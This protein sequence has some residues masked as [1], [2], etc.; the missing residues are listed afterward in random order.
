MPRLGSTLEMNHVEFF[1][2]SR[3]E[4]CGTSLHRRLNLDE[5]YVERIKKDFRIPDYCDAW[6]LY[7]SDPACWARYYN[8]PSNVI[9][10]QSE[11]VRDSA[12]AAG[13]P[14]RRNVFEYGYPEPD[15]RPRPAGGSPS[16]RASRSP[17]SFAS[18]FGNWTAS[19]SSSAPAA[20]DVPAARA[21]DVRLADIRRLTRMPP[22]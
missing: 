12:A 22:T 20:A 13:V 8:A 10:A 2:E 1:G 7:N 14:S 18:R 6:Q 3:R 16:D 4:C 5:V 11:M 19:Q 21:E 17:P 9:D 15:P